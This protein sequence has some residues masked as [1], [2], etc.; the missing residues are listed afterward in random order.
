MQL[1][2]TVSS[3]PALLNTKP[4]VLLA[5][6]NANIL[7]IVRGLL[8][9]DFDVVA[10]VSDGRKA[11]DLSFTLDPDVIVLDVSMPEL[12]GYQTLREL[13]Q[14]GSRAKVL[15]LSLHQDKTLATEAIRCGAEGY[16]LKERMFSDL[17][18]AIDHTLAGRVFVPFLTALTSVADCRHAANFH[19]KD[20]WFLDE[21]SE[22]V[23]ST[24]DSG[25]SIVV[26]A[27]GET[28]AGI[29]DRLKARGMNL[30]AIGAAQRYVAMDA[31]ECLKQ[32]MRDGRPDP[33]CLTRMVGDLE[34]LR[35][36]SPR[37]LQSR[38]TIVGEMAALLFQNG[39]I[40]A[41]VELEKIWTHL[42]LGL[43]FVTLCTYPVECF[44]NEASRLM[45]TRICDEHRAITHTT[46]PI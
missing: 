21:L 23:V 22:F 46:P 40:E 41:A 29:A 34:R 15:L 4:R 2:R 31:A 14:S 30:A 38:L 10:A 17:N 1:P 3:N 32:F 25:E 5:D 11:L 33:D 42:T 18:S 19:M 9:V 8:S 27:T 20:R 12:D 44:Q 24:L 6:D 36:S 43:P 45:F 16:V 39:S 37:G 7:E 35:L 28:R 26:I 13:R